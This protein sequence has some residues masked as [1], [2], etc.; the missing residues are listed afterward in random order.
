M[1]SS[2]QKVYDGYEEIHSAHAFDLNTSIQA[3][4]RRQYPGLNLTVVQAKNVPLLE[5]AAAGNATA[6]LDITTDSIMRLRSYYSG[7][8]RSGILTNWPK[9]DRLQNTTTN[10][11]RRNLS[12]TVFPWGRTL[13]VS[14]SF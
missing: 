2:H 13:A 11:P 1:T 7:T 4:R 9:P 8:A 6:E 5:F 10:G 3:A 12:C 14:I